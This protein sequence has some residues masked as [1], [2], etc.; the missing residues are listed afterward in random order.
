MLELE[1]S[2]PTQTYGD[3][4]GYRIRYGI[5]NQTLKEEFIQDVHQH[6]YKITDLGKFPSRRILDPRISIA[7]FFAAQGRGAW[8]TSSEWRGRT[9]SGSGRRRCDTGSA[10]RDYRPAPRPIY[11]TSSKR[12]TRC[13]LRGTCLSGSTGTVR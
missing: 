8:I 2:Q 1:W 11:P 13:A 10:R 9:R 3:L 7:R 4:L 5:K 6:A 12:R